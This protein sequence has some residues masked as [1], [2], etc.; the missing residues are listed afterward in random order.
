[1]AAGTTALNSALRPDP[2]RY[3]ARRPWRPGNLFSLDG[4]AFT[5]DAAGTLNP[6]RRPALLRGQ[7]APPHRVGRKRYDSASASPARS[8]SAASSAATASPPRATPLENTRLR[9]SG[10]GL[11][12]NPSRTITSPTANANR[13]VRRQ[14]GTYGDSQSFAEA[15]LARA[16]KSPDHE[17]R[18]HLVSDSSR[19]RR[20]TIPSASSTASSWLTGDVLEKPPRRDR[21]LPHR[22]LAQERTETRF[23]TPA[24]GRHD[25]HTGAR[26]GECVT[27]RVRGPHAHARPNF[28]LTKTLSSSPTPRRTSA[29]PTIPSSLDPTARYLRPPKARASR[30]GPDHA[31]RRRAVRPVSLSM[32]RSSQGDQRHGVNNAFRPSYNYILQDCG[33]TT[34]RRNWP[35]IRICGRASAPMRHASLEVPRHREPD[36]CSISPVN[37][38]CSRTTPTRTRRRTTLPAHV[39]LFNQLKQ[40]VAELDAANPNAAGPAA[41]CPGLPT[42]NPSHR[43]RRHVWRQLV[44]R[45]EDLDVRA[46]VSPGVRARSTRRVSPACT[47]SP[48]D[49]CAVVVDRRR[50]AL[51]KCVACRLQTL[52]RRTV[53]RQTTPCSSTDATLRHAF[54]ASWGRTHAS[55]CN[56]TPETSSTTRSF[57]IR[58]QRTTPT[59]LPAGISRPRAR[60]SCRLRSS[61]NV[62]GGALNPEAVSQARPVQKVKCHVA[63]RSINSACPPSHCRRQILPF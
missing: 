49:A 60:S 11:R 26:S 14:Y 38:G 6:E 20:R 39:P 30:P 37:S 15:R 29:C 43:Q 28:H 45:L 4:Y 55:N 51:P 61:C 62:A 31:A 22:Q 59:R 47:I 35:I 54:H 9:L 7:L 40:F 17:Q 5:R 56:S 19:I 34:R 33:P 48:A 46:L 52:D 23:D 41:A 10:G 18:P 50:R 42:P 21:R 44:F 27:L 57:R 58:Q 53:L 13:L 32:R 8:I 25:R 1:V 2:N 16:A 12:R 24:L 63:S 36:G 3:F